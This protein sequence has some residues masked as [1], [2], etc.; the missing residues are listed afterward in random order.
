M[1]IVLFFKRSLN[2]KTNEAATG[3]RRKSLHPK[4]RRSLSR[5]RCWRA[6]KSWRRLTSENKLTTTAAA[7]CSHAMQSCMS[8]KLHVSLRHV[9]TPQSGAVFRSVDSDGNLR[10]SCRTAWT[11]KYKSGYRLKCKEMLEVEVWYVLFWVLCREKH[12]FFLW[13]SH[14]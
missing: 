13:F 2:A 10:P 3:R 8:W 14:K 6:S 7:V 4:Y 11:R 12:V 1:Q 5:R 9:G